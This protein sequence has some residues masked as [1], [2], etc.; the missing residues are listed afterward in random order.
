MAD[1]MS[2]TH[3][4]VVESYEKTHVYPYPLVSKGQVTVIV[5]LGDLSSVPIE[6]GYYWTGQPKV[7][8]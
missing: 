8:R 6:E 1:W 7:Y 5:I 2:H 4:G 3:C